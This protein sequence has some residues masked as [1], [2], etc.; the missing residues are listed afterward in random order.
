M[1]DD[2]KQN[3]T[4]L[5]FSQCHSKAAMKT[6][7]YRYESLYLAS[8][9]N[10]TCSARVLSLNL[11]EALH[12]LR[13]LKSF[14]KSTVSPRPRGAWIK[15]S[16]WSAGVE[17]TPQAMTVSSLLFNQ[18]FSTATCFSGQMPFLLPNQQCQSTKA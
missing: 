3:I 16:L 17:M 5:Q 14:K 8:R 11:C 15:F 2:T 1:L 13:I 6:N 18:T 12:N 4:T 7:T 9:A 10:M